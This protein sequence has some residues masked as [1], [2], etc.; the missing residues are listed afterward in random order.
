[1]FGLLNCTRYF[2]TAHGLQIILNN[3]DFV[4]DYQDR[5][6]ILAAPGSG[7]T[8]LTRLL[9]GIDLPDEG[10]LL[11][12]R[13]D[14]LP[15]GGNSFILPG[16]TGEENARMMASFYG[17][18]GDEFSHF[19]YQLTQLE[20][21]YADKVSSYSV[22]MK[23]HLAYAINLLLPCR[24]YVADDKLY[25]GDSASQQ[26][27]QTALSRELQKKGLVV[28]TRNPRL[29][30]QHCRA[31]GVLLHGKIIRCSTL[32][33][34]TA[35]FERYQSSEALISADDNTFDI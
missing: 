7:K 2:D 11:G 28:L 5:I 34:A 32:E 21:R 27:M 4:M 26:R 3:M 20:Q 33:H 15:L 10:C 23:A 16:L 17:L 24:L 19:C 13:G 14:A 22:T 31:F 30:K 1:M 6:G 8:T 18:D 29:I 12:E 9:C 25:T 35:L